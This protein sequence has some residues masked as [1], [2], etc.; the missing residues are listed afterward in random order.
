MTQTI[1]GRAY[2]SE[3]GERLGLPKP[4]SH[5]Y[6]TLNRGTLAI[7]ELQCRAPPPDPTPS[8][9]YDDAY[10]VIVNLRHMRLDLWFN[11]S[12]A[13][14]ETMHAGK[15]Y[16]TDLRREPRV[17]IQNPFHTVNFYMP[18]AALKAYA[19]QNEMPILTDFSQSP[20]VG[21]DDPVMR[22]LAGAASAAFAHPHQASGLLL[23]AILDAVCANVLG[24][25]GT[26]KSTASVRSHGLAP[27]QERRAKELMDER[28]DVSMSELAEECGLSV[29]HF[30]RAFKR[31]TGIAP[32]QWQL[33]RRMKRAQA[34]LTGSSLSIAEIALKCGFSSQSHFA[35]AFKENIGV[36]PG[37]W[38]RSAATS[39]SGLDTD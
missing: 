39:I 23:D 16:L 5:V 35:T 21:Q 37:Y 27:W 38:R 34:L 4:L 11:D 14:S 18:N 7:T 30:G 19:E 15:T 17:L 36:S 20:T 2:G 25:Y 28:L 9:G 31:S 22:Q 33:S 26:S 13:L 12:V 3:L 24:R 1:K 32:H 10:Q 8:F 6:R 29:A